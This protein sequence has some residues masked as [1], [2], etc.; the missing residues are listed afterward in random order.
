M[1]RLINWYWDSF[2]NW[3]RFKL[4]PKE[5]Q[6]L[7]R[8]PS[9]TYFKYAPTH[10][11][12]GRKVLNFGCGKSVYKTPN[13]TN[14]DVVEG[15]GIDVVCTTNALPFES[16]TFD[17]I[18]AN[19][20]LEHVPNWFES[21][22]ELARVLKPGGRLEIWIPPI[23]SDS[24]FAYRDHINRIGLLSFSGCFSMPK[25]GNNAL[26]EKDFKE[27]ADFSRLKLVRLGK[28]PIVAWFTLL[29][30]PALLDWMAAHL[31]NMISEE[32]YLFEKV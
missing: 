14:L 26:A 18:I 6:Q 23:S 30:W 24:A 12:E 31:R 32:L 10:V 1:R 15:D 16:A 28:R 21:L 7:G 3:K 8:W 5:V 22:K 29:A 13:V 17:F 11:F 9:E 20:V 27:L 25:P 19:H 2:R 4:L